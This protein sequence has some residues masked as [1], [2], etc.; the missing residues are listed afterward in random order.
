M[1]PVYPTAEVRV[2][3][4]ITTDTH[5]DINTT[6]PI[7]THFQSNRTNDLLPQTISATTARW[8]MPRRCSTPTD[9]STAYCENI[10]ETSEKN[11]SRPLDAEF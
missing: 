7:S 8:L 1:N 6:P 11:C 10:R 3:T 5:N 2:T 9:D 4:T